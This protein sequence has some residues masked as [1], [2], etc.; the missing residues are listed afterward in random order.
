M[1][2]QVGYVAQQVA[3]RRSK[4]GYDPPTDPKFSQEWY[5]V[6][7]G[8]SGEGRGWRGGGRGGWNYGTGGK[9]VGRGVSLS[10]DTVFWLCR[11]TKEVRAQQRV[12]T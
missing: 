1:C 8:G 4:R 10:S 5:L 6:S 3:K 9:G 12:L 11:K 7:A 2:V